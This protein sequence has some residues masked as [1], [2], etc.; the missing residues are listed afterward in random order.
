MNHRK[1]IAFVI[2]HT[3]KRDVLDWIRAHHAVLVFHELYAV[4]CRVS[5][6]ER[7]LGLE[8]L[9]LQ[10][11]EAVRWAVTSTTGELPQ[12]DMVICFWNQPEALPRTPDERALVQLAARWN[13]PFACNRASADVMVTALPLVSELGTALPAAS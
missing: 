1:R 12:V 7:D 8:I 13:L 3:T 4:G 9:P 5:E 2:Q 11:G 10:R 6:L